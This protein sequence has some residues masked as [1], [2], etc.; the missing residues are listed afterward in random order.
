[1]A[2]IGLLLAASLLV[3][4]GVAQAQPEGDAAARAAFADGEAAMARGDAR[5]AVDHFRRSLGLSATAAAAYNLAVALG[6]A[7]E[8]AA[9]VLTLD[10]LLSGRYGGLA[11]DR[12]AE[13][14]RLRASYAEAA[15]L[16]PRSPPL[17]AARTGPSTVRTPPPLADHDAARL[18]DEPPRVD[19]DDDALTDSPWFWVALVATVAA[20]VT[21]T[22]ILVWPAE[23]EPVLG[24]VETLRF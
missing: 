5:A 9:G 11:S 8:P 21:V 24:T 10:A 19:R 23:D 4:I 20:A 18:R 13:V 7:G 1:V 3:P 16:P 6:D 12:R 15:G 17:D 22:A 14:E 2:V